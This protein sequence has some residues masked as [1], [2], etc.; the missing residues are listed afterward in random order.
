VNGHAHRVKELAVA[1]TGVVYATGHRLTHTLAAKVGNEGKGASGCTFKRSTVEAQFLQCV[2]CAS[3]IVACSGASPG[4]FSSPIRASEAPSDAG[5]DSV[6]ATVDAT[7][8][9]LPKMTLPA[10]PAAATDDPPAVSSDSATAPAVSLDA[11]S[12]SAADADASPEA[13]SAPISC[14][15]TFTATNVPVDGFIF[16]NAILGG[17]ADALGDWAPSSVVKM[18]AAGGT[19]GIYTVSV[20][21]ADGLAV[22]FKFGVS[23]SSGQV[24]WESATQPTDR[25]LVVSCADGSQPAYTG[26]F[27]QIP[28]AGGP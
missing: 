8:S 6:S 22:H 15:V 10:S 23:D 18:P 2:F 20:P 3:G 5:L 13:D 25:V 14:P 24:T 11:S 26:Q 4:A 9:P 17:D 16:Q 12:P 21:L 19:V 1:E 7:A 28:D 27:N